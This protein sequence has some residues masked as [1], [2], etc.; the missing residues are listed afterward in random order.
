[1]KLLEP[2]RK[3]PTRKPIY[4]TAF[5][6]SDSD[7]GIASNQIEDWVPGLSVRISMPKTTRIENKLKCAELFDH[8]AKSFTA[9]N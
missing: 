4:G 5:G 8:Y 6:M 1:M 3:F 7:V 9:G 2:V